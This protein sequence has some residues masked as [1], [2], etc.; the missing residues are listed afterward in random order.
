MLLIPKIKQMLLQQ[1]TSPFITLYIYPHEHQMLDGFFFFP[2]PIPEAAFSN[3]VVP[4][5]LMSGTPLP[6]EVSWSY[7]FSIS[8]SRAGLI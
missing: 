6:M 1:K 8:F 4:I 3:Q 7:A 5:R 2:L